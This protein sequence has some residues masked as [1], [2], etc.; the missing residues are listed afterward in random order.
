MQIWIW[1]FLAEHEGTATGLDV[2]GLCD[3]VGQP[4]GEALQQEPHARVVRV[5]PR[6]D[7]HLQQ[8][9]AGAL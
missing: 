4:A 8:S 1:S 6:D 9:T 2:K 7:P 3:A 5:V